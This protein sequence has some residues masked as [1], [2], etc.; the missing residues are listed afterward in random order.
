MQGTGFWVGAIR[1]KDFGAEAGMFVSRRRGARP[2]PLVLRDP[3]LSPEV[4]GR[5]IEA[6]PQAPDLAPENPSE[7]AAWIARQL[8]ADCFHFARPGTGRR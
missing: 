7:R 1:M 3:M 2:A 5:S 6:A 8:A 4:A